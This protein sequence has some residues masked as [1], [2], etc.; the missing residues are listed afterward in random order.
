MF[1]R[2]VL[3]RSFETELT[4]DGDG[5]TI[6]GRCVPYGVRATVRDAGG[7]SYAELFEPGAFRHMTRAARRV[8]LRFEH[9]EGLVDIVGHATDLEDRPDGLWG[10]FRA[11]SGPGADVA[12]ELIAADVLTGLSVG[13][14]PLTRPPV[15]SD[16]TVVRTRCH[17]DEVS[18]VR[19]AAYGPGLLAVRSDAPAEPPWRELRPT[20]DEALEAR[21]SALLTPATEGASA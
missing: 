10:C 15:L 8:L 17:L 20:R 11:V 2:T 7:P 19:E 3:T 9:R 14:V 18:L 12:L 6:S 4:A 21:I 5:R 16:G 13:F 1:E